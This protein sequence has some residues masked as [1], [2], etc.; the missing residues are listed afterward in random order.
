LNPSG[1]NFQIDITEQSN[2]LKDFTFGLMFEKTKFVATNIYSPSEFSDNNPSEVPYVDSET[3]VIYTGMAKLVAFIKTEDVESDRANYIIVREF[4]EKINVI[5]S[6]NYT[7]ISNYTKIDSSEVTTLMDTYNQ[8]YVD[9][10]LGQV[11]LLI[12][13]VARFSQSFISTISNEYNY[14]DIGFGIPYGGYYIADKMAPSKLGVFDNVTATMTFT[15]I[16]ITSPT[17]TYNTSVINIPAH[18][19][20][21]TKFRKVDLNPSGPLKD[22][23]LTLNIDPTPTAYSIYRS[24]SED[25]SESFDTSLSDIVTISFT[26]WDAKDRMVVTYGTEE[27]DSGYIATNTTGILVFDLDVSDL[28]SIYVE[29]NMLAGGAYEYRIEFKENADF[30]QIPITFEGINQSVGMELGTCND[31]HLAWQSN[32]DMNWNI[33]YSSS[34]DKLSPFRFD[35]KITNTESNSLRPSVSVNRNGARLI[36]WHDDRNGNYDI[37]MARATDGYDCDQDKCKKE[38][39]D[40]FDYNINE[41]NIAIDY[42]S[43]AGTYSLSLQFYKDAALSE[44]YTIISVDDTTEDRWFVDGSQAVIYY[45]SERSAQGVIFSTDGDVVISYIPDKD[46]GIFDI[47]LYVKLVTTEIA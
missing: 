1:G 20:D 29:T 45:D 47:V 9:K 13:S 39:A 18:I 42:E 5:D 4:P 2:N 27:Y 40:A 8:T 35:T 23:L 16:D 7:I 11:T 43:I 24:K 30:A 41:C 10:F 36:T 22:D 15:G 28:D 32:R 37:F 3:H 38:M 31:V 21:M 17:Y 6:K 14:F 12:D 33:F 25:Y 19:R 44:L 46:D 26:T 34:V